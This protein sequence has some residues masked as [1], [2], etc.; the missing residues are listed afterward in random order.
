[1]RKLLLVALVAALASLSVTATA[2]AV[3]GQ[4]R[5]SGNGPGQKY[6]RNPAVVAD[7]ATTYLFF[8]RSQVN[9]SRLPLP[10]A[11]GCP[12]NIGYDL[13]VKASPDGGKTFGP[14]QLVDT[15]PTGP[16][17]P[18]YGRTISA[19]ATP[20]GVHVFWTNGGSIGPV[21][22]YFKPTGS[23]T[24]TPREETPNTGM[25][26]FNAWAVS[27]GSE[28]LLYTEE[29]C[30][31]LQG[32]YARRY[33]AAGP[34]LTPAGGPTKVPGSED[35]NIPK[36]MV[37]D[38]GIVR[39]VMVKPAEGGV[40]VTS[41]ADGLTFPPPVL[42]APADEGAIN[43]DPNIE[44]NAGGVYFLY[45]A[46]DD[47]TGRQRI[48]VTSSNDF[49]NW[50]A[51]REVSPGQTAG[52]PYWDYWPEPFRRGNQLVLFYTSERGF[53]DGETMSQ[54]PTGQGHVWSNPGFGGSDHLGPAA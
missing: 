35:A 41:S 17:G 15:N 33:T 2:S 11:P 47:G 30:G 31:P 14:A 53:T 16:A 29:C 8:A 32:I 28:V 26:V 34:A 50:S 6:D 46:P 20:D 27:R 42:A 54:Y 44:Q 43:W 39:L 1:M 37:D 21:Y 9:C 23:S 13:Y 3:V 22:H 45:F 36:A 52:T 24:F 19:T 40:F 4:A 10:T 38:L 49:A 18:F 7:G 25:N 48:G 5:T 12:D 51:T